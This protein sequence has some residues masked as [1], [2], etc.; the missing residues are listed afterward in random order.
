MINPVAA[1]AAFHITQ[2]AARRRRERERKMAK[3]RRE[4]ESK[5]AKKNKI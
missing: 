5:P 2:R 4:K 3:E 1:V